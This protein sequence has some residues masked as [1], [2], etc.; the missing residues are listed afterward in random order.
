[1]AVSKV[2]KGPSSDIFP[3]LNFLTSGVHDKRLSD[4]LNGWRT[5][6]QGARRRGRSECSLRESKVLLFVKSECTLI[7]QQ[8]LGWFGMFCSG[9][10]RLS[11]D[12][13]GC[14]L[15]RFGCCSS[16]LLTSWDERSLF[17]PFSSLA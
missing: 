5:P 2:R 9:A 7:F 8:C 1:M 11:R 10:M 16:T 3:S 14:E 13:G 17:H 4:W 15:L 12:A 6:E